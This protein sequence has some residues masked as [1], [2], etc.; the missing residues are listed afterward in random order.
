[1]R[2]YSDCYIAFVDLL[3]FK[4]LV[5]SIS[6]EEIACIFDEINTDYIIT[7]NGTDVPCVSPANVKKKVM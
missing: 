5:N 3:G 2:S 4:R 1:M 6:C 7:I